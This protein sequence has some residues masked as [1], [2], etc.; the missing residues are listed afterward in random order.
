MPMAQIVDVDEPETWPESVADW[1]RRR[2]TD[3]AG[4]SQYT[5]DLPIPIEE[6]NSFRSFF[7]DRPLLAF[8]CTRLLDHEAAW[9]WEQGLRPL[10]LELV[11][12]RIDGAFDRGLIDNSERDHLHA[13]HTF[14]AG[15]QKARQGQICFVVGRAVLAERHSGCEPLL[16]TWGGEGIYMAATSIR[17]RLAR[18]GT[19]SLI[20]ARVWLGCDHWEALTFPSLAQLFV[21]AVLGAEPLSC[22]L[23]Y[24]AT[25]PAGDILTILQPGDAEYDVFPHLPRS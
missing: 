17:K 18:L 10:S 19:P 11:S 15:T 14:A 13:S 20:K 8:H 21:G 22:D 12:E 16:S 7:G 6:E 3:V 1:A 2:A 9:I 23:F 24:R 4:S 5:S 25:V